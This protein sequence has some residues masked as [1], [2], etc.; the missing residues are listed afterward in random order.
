M[1]CK[2]K[3]TSHFRWFCFVPAFLDVRLL[4]CYTG[5]SADTRPRADNSWACRAAFRAWFEPERRSGHVK[6]R[7]LAVE[8]EQDAAQ[9]AVLR[10]G[11]R[12]LS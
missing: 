2:M 12:P 3:K 4:C 1:N 10:A 7:L 5:A 6:F 9:E 8:R 11:L